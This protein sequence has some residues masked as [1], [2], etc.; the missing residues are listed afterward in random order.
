[1]KKACFVRHPGQARPFLFCSHAIRRYR[2]AK[3][4]RSLRSKA[5]DWQVVAPSK[6]LTLKSSVQESE[7]NL[8]QVAPLV[9]DEDILLDMA[10]FSLFTKVREA[11]LD[12]AFR[13][14]DLTGEPFPL[15]TIARN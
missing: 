6:G 9:A 2:Q 14:E 8:L 12:A 4:S 13:A 5:D 10:E 15:A 3:P 7:G 11:I 1:M